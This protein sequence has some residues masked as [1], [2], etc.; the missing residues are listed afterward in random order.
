M[1]PADRRLS[2]HDAFA[3]CGQV[4]AVCGPQAVVASGGVCL[5][6]NVNVDQS[7][8]HMGHGGPS[9]AGR[10]SRL[11]S[12]SRA[13]LRFVTPPDLG[14]VDLQGSASG[15]G[16]ATS[17]WTEAT[18]ASPGAAVKPVYHVA[19]GNEQLVY[20]NAIPTRIGF[21]NLDVCSA[22]EQ[23]AANTDVAIAAAAREAELELLT[24]MYNASKQVQPEQ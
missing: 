5:P 24:Q 6:V 11:S 17:V 10:A 4:D 9:A 21:G 14:V 8:A 16:S 20:V 23:V 18:D 1:Y 2:Q 12:R 19:C 13:G 7:G 3:N 22:P 15:L